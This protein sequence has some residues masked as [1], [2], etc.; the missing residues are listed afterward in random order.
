MSIYVNEDIVSKI[1][2]DKNS[3]GVLVA[4]N[5]F[6][7]KGETAM[8]LGDQYKPDTG[9]D[10]SIENVFF[11]NNLFLKDHWPKEVLIQPSKSVIGDPFFKNAGGELIS[12]YFPLNIDLIKDKGI[13]IT[14]IV[15]DSIGLRI[16][17]K[18]DMDILGNP[19]KNMPDLGAIEIN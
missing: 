6:Y 10:G 11:E 7:Y 9:G 5:I 13:D 3:K 17:L 1:A 2:V 12:D 8:V 15:N 14:N 4:N 18:V 19:I 16:G